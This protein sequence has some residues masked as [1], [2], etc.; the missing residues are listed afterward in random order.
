[1]ILAFLWMLVHDLISV[2][3]FPP[4]RYIMVDFVPA[5]I[6]CNTYYIRHRLQHHVYMVDF[7]LTHH[8]PPLI[9][10]DLRGVK[11]NKS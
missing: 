11:M 6:G 7:W 9:A 8:N 10:L 5:A 3:K 2:V 1:M 4:W